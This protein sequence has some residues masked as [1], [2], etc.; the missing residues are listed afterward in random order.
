M[1]VSGTGVM[2]RGALVEWSCLVH[3][4]TPAALRRAGLPD[5][6]PNAT[7]AGTQQRLSRLYCWWWYP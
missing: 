4:E 1:R 3:V 5:Y 7:V 2:P 6:S